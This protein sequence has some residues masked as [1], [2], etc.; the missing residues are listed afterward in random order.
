MR[1]YLSAAQVNV[2]P[3]KEHA[4]PLAHLFWAQRSFRRLV[5]HAWSRH[6]REAVCNV[7]PN[8]GSYHQPCCCPVLQRDPMS[9]RNSRKKTF[10]PSICPLC[11]MIQHFEFQKNWIPLTWVSLHRFCMLY[12]APP[13][14]TVNGAQSRPS[15]D[16]IPHVFSVSL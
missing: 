12:V 1:R 9:H 4:D 3:F 14:P 10:R 6:E 2:V 13:T 8:A 16:P 5:I 15:H 7:A 11:F